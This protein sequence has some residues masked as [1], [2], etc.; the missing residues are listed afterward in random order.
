MGTVFKKKQK[1]ILDKIN[2]RPL[3]GM[4]QIGVTKLL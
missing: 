3:Q 2:K 4:S 1:T